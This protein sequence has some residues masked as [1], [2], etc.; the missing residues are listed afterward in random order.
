MNKK[1]GKLKKEMFDHFECLS[2]QENTKRISI[3]EYNSELDEAIEEAKRGETYTHEEV[4]KM[5]LKW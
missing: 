4:K 3:E 5:S 1:K 2:K